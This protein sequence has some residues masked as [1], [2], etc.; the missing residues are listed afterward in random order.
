VYARE[1]PKGAAAIA[2]VTPAG[3]R[4]VYIPWN[5]GEI[6]WQVYAV[7]HGRLIANAVHWALG[8]APRVTVTGPGVLDIAQRESD[9]G[10]ALTL[11]NLTNPMMLKGPVRENL[12]LGPQT[13]TVEIPPGR[14]VAAARLVVAGQAAATHVQ[15]GKLHVDIPAIE[16]LEMLHITWT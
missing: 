5:I 11:H 10:L 1:E 8:K 13:V 2:R 15:D 16:R 7:D 3:G 14:T 6:F 9:D 4:V 12:P